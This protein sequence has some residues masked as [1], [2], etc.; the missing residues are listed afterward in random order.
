MS[1]TLLPALLQD[2]HSNSVR[3]EPVAPL[4]VLYQVTV[5]MLSL[6]LMW[7]VDVVF[8]IHHPT[9]KHVPDTLLM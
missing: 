5:A 2:S 9:G 8:L 1:V 6:S 4:L 3:A 7:T